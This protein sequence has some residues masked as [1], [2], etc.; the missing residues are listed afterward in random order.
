MVMSEMSVD[1]RTEV[2]GGI[3]TEKS[4]DSRRPA[5]GTDWGNIGIVGVAA[6][7]VVYS[8]W[9]LAGWG[10]ADRVEMVREL[11]FLPLMALGAVFAFR[12][13]YTFR[14]DRRVHRAWM[15][16]GFALFAWFL[17]DAGWAAHVLLGDEFQVFSYASLGFVGAVAL[18]IAGIYSFPT[19]GVSERN[20]RVFRLDSSIILAGLIALTGSV[21]IGPERLR[22]TS[23]DA[24]ALSLFL[25]TSITII[26]LGI[27]YYTIARRPAAGLGAPL[28]VMT[29]GLTIVALANLTWIHFEVRDQAVDGGPIYVFWML[30]QSLFVIGPQLHRDLTRRSVT[31]PRLDSLISRSH[32]FIPYAAAG[33]GTVVLVSTGVAVLLERMGIIIIVVLT[34]ISLII[35]RQI[36]SLRQNA[37]YQA[38]EAMREAENWYRTLIAYSSDMVMVLDREYRCTYQSPSAAALSTRALATPVGSQFLDWVHPDDRDAVGQA[39]NQVLNSTFQDETMRIEWRL[40]VHDERAV[41]Y[42]TIVSNRLD[43]PTVRGLVLN[44]RDTS[45]RKQLE[46]Q[47]THQAYHDS[48]TGLPN[49]AM[50]IRTLDQLASDSTPRPGVAVIFADIDEFKMINDRFGHDAGDELLRAFSGRLRMALGSEDFLSRLAGDEF[51]IVL[52]RVE[53]PED[54]RSI[55]ERVLRL[56][57]APFPIAGVEITLTS[58]VGIAVSPAGPFDPSELIRR[59]DTAMY[60]AKEIGQGAV[61]FYEPW[62]DGDLETRVEHVSGAAE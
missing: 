31:F 26:A 14:S 1:S 17:G 3:L 5:W 12:A 22:L 46:E 21:V 23:G 45:E 16:I 51:T 15:L 61:V 32:R 59:A 4:A 33:A 56:M 49:R 27:A 60:A 39:L 50:L 55:G 30:G 36:I 6:G 25:Y 11:A 44:S 62:M 13:A 57:R 19:I 47:L 40:N 38:A 28:L 48:L 9:V 24:E 10:G 7:A 42:E 37:R 34:V 52:D 29:L 8:L 54:V 35:I 53:S 18:I 41:H 58:S 2:S 20:R 43:D